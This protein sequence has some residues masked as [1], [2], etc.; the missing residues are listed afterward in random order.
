MNIEIKL[1]AQVLEMLDRFKIKQLA[2][3]KSL[4][5]DTSNPV[6]KKSWLSRIKEFENAGYE[7]LADEYLFDRAIRELRESGES[8]G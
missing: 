5:E 2:V 4:V 7:F 6:V 8:N 1:S 3:L